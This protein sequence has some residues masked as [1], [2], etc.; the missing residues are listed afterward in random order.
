[1]NP[2]KYRNYVL[3]QLTQLERKVEIS[4]SLNRTDLNLDCEDFYREL[5]NLIYGLNL[6]N[7][8]HTNPNQ[9]TFDLC[10]DDAG[11]VYQITSSVNR[12]KVRKT[13][14]QFEEKYSADYDELYMV[15]L[16][17]KN[18][19]EGSKRQKIT[20]FKS[21][22]GFS[23]EKH[24][25]DNLDIIKK[26]DSLEDL[27]E[28]KAVYELVRKYFDDT[29]KEKEAKEGK[30]YSNYSQ[31][32][33]ED[34][35]NKL[36]QASHH[37]IDYSDSFVGVPD[38][39]FQRKET[40]DLLNWIEETIPPNEKPVALLVG[41]AGRGKTV[42]L[43]D[44]FLELRRT[45]IPVVGLKADRYYA[46]SL[47][48]LEQKVHLEDSFEKVLRSLTKDCAKAVVLIDQ[49]D[50]L[51]QS[52]SAKRQYIDTY[53]LLVRKLITIPN[54]RV[55]ISVRS[56]DLNYDTDL[57]FYK[58]QRSFSVGLLESDQVFLILGKLGIDHN[59]VPQKLL[60]LLQ[61]PHHLNVF[62][63]VYRNDL[64]LILINTLHDLYNELWYQ[65]VTETP[66]D[67]EIIESK[68][69]SLLFA[70]AK[71]MYEGQHLSIPSNSYYH[72]YDHELG[73]LKSSG[74]LSE[75]GQDLQFFHQSFFDFAF[76]KQFVDGGNSIA[77]HLRDN[78]QGLFVRSS[79]KMIL[80]YLREQ[81]HEKYIQT[82]KK[83]LFL[84]RYRLHLKIMILNILGYQAI[85][86]MEEKNLIKFK[87]LNSGLRKSFLESVNSGLWLEFLIQEDEM[88]SLLRP[89]QKN[90]ISRIIHSSWR[91]IG[92]R[93]EITESAYS[94]R[95]LCFYILRRHLPN[96]RKSICKFL[97]EAGEFQD[98]EA[99]IF[100]TLYFINE[101][102]FDEAFRLFK[103]C[104]DQAKQDLFYYYKILG[105]I[106]PYDFEF[107]AEEYKP[108][109]Q[110]KIDEVNEPFQRLQITYDDEELIKK[111]F[112]CNTFKAFEYFLHFI[113]KI[114]VLPFH[115]YDYRGSAPKH[116]QGLDLIVE[117][118]LSHVR[119]Q[120]SKSPEWFK[121]FFKVQ[122]FSD[123]SPH[124]MI[125]IE[126]LRTDPGLFYEESFDF[127]KHWTLPER[128]DHGKGKVQHLVRKLLGEAY[129]LLKSS[130]QEDL[131]RNLLNIYPKNEK[132][133][134]IYNQ[135]RR[136]PLQWNGHT[137]YLFLSAIPQEE[138]FAKPHLK[139]RFN[140]LHRKFGE[141]KDK[142]P[143]RFFTRGIEPPIDSKAYDKMSHDDWIATFKKYNE[144]YK[145]DF[146]SFKGSLFEHTTAFQNEVKKRPGFFMPL[147]NRL[148]DENKVHQNYITAGLS[149]LKEAEFNPNELQKIFQKA[150]I[151][152]F[153]RNHTLQ[154][155]SITSYFI[156]TRV[157]EEATLDFLIDMA[158]NHPDPDNKAIQN[159]II[160]DCLN[161]VR[162]AATINIVETYFNPEFETKIFSALKKIA[163]DP[164]I[165][166]RV[167]ILLKMAN[168]RHLNEDKALNLFLTLVK[169]GESEILRY[170]GWSAQ[171]FAE[172]HF[173][174][175]IPYFKDMIEV[176]DAAEHT[177]TI[178]SVRWIEGQDKAYPLLKELFKRSDKAK[179][180]AIEVSV[181]NLE[182]ENE[183]AV[184][185]CR[186][187]YRLFLS[188]KSDEV[189]RTYNIEFLHFP[190]KLFGREYSILKNYSR[191]V[192]CKMQPQYYLQYLL[193]CAKKH[194]VKCLHL[195][196]EVPS[197]EK[198]D[199]TQSGHYDDEPVKILIGAYNSLN[200]QKIKPMKD[201]EN[202]MKLFDKLLKD[203]RFRPSANKA[204]ELV[205]R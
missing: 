65:Y 199:I 143:N 40:T 102:D 93:P 201:L 92:S 89:P 73:Y 98:R 178:L 4:V 130:Q 53:N 42:I 20:E 170:T 154:L 72:E 122:A 169:K 35:L 109:F 74:V 45:G 176:E 177:G 156:Q 204:I 43:K 38:S 58:N 165:T 171:F 50:A 146:S 6:K 135:E 68:L 54:V 10:D 27:D 33:K 149:G 24:L 12:E 107:V 103:N 31:I 189:A 61:T 180:K 181:R 125:I 25:L 193:R 104:K 97:C 116:S 205:D 63:K 134:F 191:S 69:Q 144:N 41:G 133:I 139:K 136:H 9:D 111:M 190:E 56:Y 1:M 16:K 11:Q 162:A 34:I 184:N 47:I 166:V 71:K 64:K 99:F 36:Y 87:I 110:R 194:P 161:N 21:S 96:N 79:V 167:A 2:R 188:S 23:V 49:I 182:N 91:K 128:V 172:S 198:P 84:P 179:A 145:P 127:L 163:N 48:E 70:I 147:V 112:L 197:Y 187:L 44:L 192:V 126:G 121:D 66:R 18:A 19:L 202:S 28:K 137:Q 138:V 168:L 85:P 52:L 141:I 77:K 86:S 175:L 129:S 14:R 76:A 159:D 173:N 82:L 22:F 62:C 39:H 105:D 30:N 37:L 83:L 29:P 26:F 5:L 88:T 108:I 115:L 51:S 123:F 157:I 118:L 120:A 17:R 3:D 113:E 200:S 131:D 174:R 80:A 119:N 150:I 155:I 75:I 106:L 148:V 32:P 185:R 152:D 183:E 117:L 114:G 100:R 132:E 67:K 7:S 13:I 101:W 59:E 153:D 142:E 8:N 94:L 203:E 195:L 140:E 164:H 55:I 57:S 15:F 186:K 95:N 78:H 90:L 46:E 158:L 151:P 60:E 196:K 124:Q 160:T 81:N